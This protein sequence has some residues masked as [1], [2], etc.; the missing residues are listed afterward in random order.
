MTIGKMHFLGCGNAHSQDLGNSCAVFEQGECRLVIDFGFTSFH[1]YRSQYNENPEAIFITHAHLDHIGG[2]EN[3]FFDAY[4]SGKPPI[5]MYVPVSLVQIVHNR[6]ASLEHTLAEGDA[7]F[8]DAFQLVP[9]SDSFWHQGLKFKVFENRH[10]QMGFSFGISL[11]GR[12]LYTGDTK[13]IPEIINSLASQ[14]E[15]IF[16][17]LSMNDQPSHTYIGEL[18][19][20]TSNVLSRCVFYHLANRDDQRE[21]ESRGLRVVRQ[22]DTFEI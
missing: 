1:A 4:F 11:P 22:S 14:G 5:K 3:L 7:N 12:F 13:P 16:H 17:D 8:W 20:Y 21:C 19:R 15:T 6:V 9:V 2:L 18:N 10:H